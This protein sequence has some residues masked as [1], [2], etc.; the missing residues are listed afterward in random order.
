MS[1]KG[2]R[3]FSNYKRE[4]KY[5]KEIYNSHAKMGT[6]CEPC[7]EKMVLNRNKKIKKSLETRTTVEELLDSWKQQILLR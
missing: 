4:C 2:R 1:T 5:C 3:G 6:V 7:K